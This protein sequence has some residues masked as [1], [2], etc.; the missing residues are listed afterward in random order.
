MT[1]AYGRSS[2]ETQGDPQ[3]AHSR[4]RIVGSK[5]SPR[6]QRNARGWRP[7][8]LWAA[9]R[10]KPS[11]ACAE[12]H[13]HVRLGAAGPP[14]PQASAH[15]AEACSSVSTYQTCWANVAFAR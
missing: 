11:E 7:E 4:T 12:K 1:G 2:R 3:Q 9:G 15:S 5:G 10:G 8:Q 6:R 14:H 13:T